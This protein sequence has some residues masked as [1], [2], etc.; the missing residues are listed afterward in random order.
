MYDIIVDLPTTSI[1]NHFTGI[2]ALNIPSE[3]IETGDWHTDETFEPSFGRKPK[4][5]LS[6]KLY[7]TNHI[8]GTDTIE[9]KSGILNKYGIFDK[10]NK[11]V[12]SA[13]HYRAIAD[14]T[15]AIL[16][17]KKNLPM[18]IQLDDW[19]PNEKYQQIFFD[20]FKKAQQYLSTED[21]DNYLLWK[22]KISH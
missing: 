18:L 4:F 6:G 14:M 17:E 22:N 5:V 13:N 3:D 7:Q 20:L 21:W 10:E 2:T 16:K 8:F 1:D 12:Y 19:L 15:Y 11:P 9:E